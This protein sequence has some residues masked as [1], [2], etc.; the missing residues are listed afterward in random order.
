MVIR[1]FFS[2]IYLTLSS[3]AGN[4]VTAPTAV[5]Y[6]RAGIYAPSIKKW[7]V[8]SFLIDTGADATIIHPQDS[9]RLYTRTQIN[10]LPNPTMFGGA[11]AGK[12]H[13]P[14]DAQIIF[15]HDHGEM[16]E[17]PTTVYVSDPSH[18]VQF[19]SLLGRDV[20]GSFI[21]NFDQAGQTITL[22]G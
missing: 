18:N 10:S 21:M 1:G 22:G 5:P 17:V 8:S 11:G 15:L 4:D 7:V 3:Q 20:L 2:N 13:Y 6:V 9:L 12:P 14:V 16:Q 19:D